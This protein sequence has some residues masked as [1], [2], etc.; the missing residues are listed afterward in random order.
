MKIKT[1]ENKEMDLIPLSGTTPDFYD[2]VR[3]IQ[4]PYIPISKELFDQ[5]INGNSDYYK[6]EDTVF[7]FGTADQ[8]YA[9]MPLMYLHAKEILD[10]NNIK[11]E[12]QKYM[13]TFGSDH[14]KCFKVNAARTILIIDA[15]NEE[16]ARNLA[17]NVEG[18]GDKFC[19][20]YIYNLN[21]S[22]LFKNNSFLTLEELEAKRLN[23][24]EYSNK[25]E[26]TYLY[27]KDLS[28]GYQDFFDKIDKIMVPGMN[29]EN[30]LY[31]IEVSKLVEIVEEFEEF[32]SDNE[33]VLNEQ[34]IIRL[35]EYILELKTK[36]LMIIS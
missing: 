9:L 26:Y 6:F 22:N 11:L 14:L 33:I 28:K 8:G 35:K 16:E 32:L 27:F 36:Y 29:V 31:L 3:M 10:K 2:A 7:T 13:I 17:Y 15:K 20:S 24:L 1:L 19:T 30:Y 5:L 34:M 23:G 21:N 25:A 12:K 18:I 4:R